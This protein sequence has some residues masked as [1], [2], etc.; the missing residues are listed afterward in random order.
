MSFNRENVIWQSKDG[1]W[2]RGFYEVIWIG[3]DD[4][5]WDP[6]WDVEYGDGFG[7][8]KTGLPSEQAAIDAW[9]GANPGGH[10]S[11]EFN[12]VN[13][14]VCDDLDKLAQQVNVL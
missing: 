10:T 9:T 2:N 7:W 14:K 6:E 5:D 1:T 13:A 3:S 4:P 12:D 11:I 8:V